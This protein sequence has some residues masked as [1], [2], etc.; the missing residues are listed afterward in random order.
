MG[1][2][3]KVFRMNDYD[4]WADFDIEA[5]QANYKKWQIEVCG[6]LASEIEIDA[7][8]LSEEEMNRLRF[9]YEDSDE[10]MSFND[11]LK[12]RVAKGEIGPQFFA[13]TEV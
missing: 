1:E 7:R 13:S 5:A 10:T 11:E 3:L 6:S 9:R 4:W 12:Y 2:K 8:E